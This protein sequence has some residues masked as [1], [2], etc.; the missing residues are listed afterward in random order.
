L[1]LLDPAT[2]TW[3]VINPI[4]KIDGFNSEEAWSLLPDGTIFTL[5]VQAAPNS[6]RYFPSTSTWV[7]A[8]PTP[9]DLHSPGY[10]DPIVV[11]PG[12]VYLPP[13]EVGP[14]IRLPNGTLF[15]EGGNGRN[16]IFTPP[17]ANS[18]SPGTWA[19]GPNFPSGLSVDDGPSAILPNGHVIAAISPPESGKGLAIVEFDGTNIVPA[20]N[21]PNAAAD[22]SNGI[23]LLLLPTGQ[24]LLVDSTNSVQLYSSS[25]TY[26]PSWAPTIA[27]LPAV[28]TS[29]STYS[30]T[31]SQFNGLSMGT[32]GGD[33]LENATNYPLVRITNNATGHVFYARTHDH[34][35]MGI[36][37]GA[38]PVSTNFD[39]PAPTELGASSLVVIA[40]GIP[41]PPVAVTIANT[42]APPITFACPAVV[43]QVNVPYNSAASAVGGQP[44]FVFSI[45]AGNLPSGLTLNP[46]TGTISGT[47]GSEE[48]AH[49]TV[50]VSD[51][52]TTPAFISTDC[53]ISISLGPIVGFQ[54]F[55]TTTQG[56]WKGVHGQDGWMIANDSSSIPSYATVLPINASQ[57]TWAGSTT[58][59]RALLKGASTTDRIAS[60]Y[61]SNSSF[62]FDINLT[63]GQTHQLAFYSL[64]FETHDRAQTI[65]IMD[66][67]NRA[68]LDTRFMSF[69]QAGIYA[70]WNLKGHVIVQ[71]TCTGGTN[72]V[73]GGIFF[74]TP[75]TAVP[76]P[77]VSITSPAPGPVSGPATIT[78]HA[79]SSASIS[80]VQIQLDNANFGSPLTGA[81]PDYSLPWQT[82]NS[83]NGNHTITAIATD[84]L[85]QSTTSSG[86]IVNVSNSSAG[87][88]ASFV[89]LDST[90]QGNWKSVY[91]NE[92]YLIPSDSNAPPSY[93][94]VT[95]SA[96]SLYTWTPST[97]DS[98]ALLKGVSTTD[99]IA[100]TYY[101]SN[102]FSLDVNLSGASSH[103]I[104]L[105]F[106]D[107]EGTSRS[108]TVTVLDAATNV[109]LD[110]R[111]ISNFHSGVFGVWNIQG[112]VLLRITNQGNPNAVVEGVFFG[113]GTSPP[114]PDSLP[115]TVSVN[116]PASGFISS[117]IS[118]TVTATA[119]APATIATVQ[120]VVDGT[121]AGTPS[122]PSGTTSTLTWNPGATPGSHSIAAMAT[123]SQGRSTT[124]TSVTV[125][126]TDVVT[127][128]SASFVK[129]DSAT[130]GS[131]KGNYGGDGQIIANDTFNLPAYASISL[132]GANQW[133][134]VG[135]SAEAR[136]LQKGMS[137]TDRIMSTYY[138]QTFTLDVNMPGGVTHQ[139]AI[140]ALDADGTARAETVAI[141]DAT[142]LTT[143]ESRNLSSF[144]DGI[145]AVWN[146]QGHVLI[147]VTNNGNPNAVVSGVFFAP[148][149]STIPPP[150]VLLTSPY[151]GTVSGQVALGASATSSITVASGQFLLDGQAMGAVISGPGPYA[152]NWDSTQTTNGAHTINARVTDSQGQ[153]S[154][155]ATGIN[156][157]VSNAAP[158]GPTVTFV[159]KD[160]TTKGTWKGTY[161]N[162]GV[163]IAGDSSSP[164]AYATTLIQ[165]GTAFTWSQTTD[166][167]GLQQFG[168]ASR[169]A[170]TFYGIPEFTIDMNIS[171]APH[172]V[173]LYFLDWD[174]SDRSE[175]VSVIDPVTQ[176]V[177]NSQTISAFQSGAYL[178]WNISGHV[179]FQIQRI[180]SNAV[181]S[182]MF[183]G[184]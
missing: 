95:P 163:I 26:D 109:A 76:P 49:F 164:P 167:R 32:G 28:L 7:S 78:A 153:S 149:P 94:S 148:V 82:T 115:P 101:S 142:T 75:A 108:E 74:R 176:Q 83:T 13:G 160:T 58:D 34:S 98:R 14:V 27:S 174:N 87:N 178:V 99:R 48:S 77:T 66:A 43:G 35:T 118:V 46:N 61:Y 134:W 33:E 168:G 40:N 107:W 106:I 119:S 44:P 184:P 20:P 21:I 84:S 121:P 41:S 100:S 117:P 105:Y 57:W 152:L 12:I 92:G 65:T 60:T 89:E 39:V 10:I 22:A 139:V 15:V 120:L 102:A 127:P 158:P 170:S 90:T 86:V 52:F 130:Q 37:T 166:Q 162:D 144:H 141:L 53:S 50:R 147:R 85:N 56:N 80:S 181:V 8:G 146:I 17:P 64:D 71:V 137:S 62:S 51:S 38:T 175:T 79:T 169:I 154:T 23:S 165:G 161:G 47:P 131:W 171:G 124:S 24:V 25:G 179:A 129:F 110:T 93:G 45:T 97:S 126:I 125:L 122:G 16:A 140:Y 157:N 1:A 2:L 91:G 67:F 113:G 104:A 173:A 68:V 133:T 114:P 150:T 103:Q 132:S 138:G 159:G 5:D 183:F 11:A 143:L 73:V 135:S 96:A 136:A 128:S 70:V 31:G 19:Q 88:A 116:A 145:W 151:P 156:I 155:A 9:L 123:D 18:T 29:G 30:V 36:A 54:K 59:V 112:H 177:L 6:E 55:D 4:G 182:G 69:M 111:T 42:V 63:D 72:A 180:T 172:R 81:G 3:T